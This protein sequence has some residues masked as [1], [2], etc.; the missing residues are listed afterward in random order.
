MTYTQKV[1]LFHRA[2][3]SF[4]VAQA[5]APFMALVGKPRHAKEARDCIAEAVGEYF[6]D[7]GM[8][9]LVHEMMDEVVI[10]QHRFEHLRYAVAMKSS[11]RPSGESEDG[12]W[13]RIDD[14]P[15]P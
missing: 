1:E 7:L 9:D 4:G 15:C 14:A 13:E 8:E 12:D 2:L 3:A 6:D 5:K 10:V 11:L